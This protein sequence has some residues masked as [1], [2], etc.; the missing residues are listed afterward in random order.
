MHYQISLSLL[1]EPAMLQR[2]LSV[3]LCTA[4]VCVILLNFLNIPILSI[5]V[6]SLEES[7][8][9]ELKCPLFDS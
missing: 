1:S 3:V 8:L 6:R 7:P 9:L 4:F 2:L 5:F